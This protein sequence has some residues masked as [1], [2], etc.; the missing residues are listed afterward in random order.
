MSQLHP[1]I[2]EL[3]EFL[4]QHRRRVHEAVASVPAE[5]RERKPAPDRWSVAEVIEHLA[6]IEQ[7]VA[8]LLTKRVTGARAS[9]VGPD[10]RPGTPPCRQPWRGHRP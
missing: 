10:H 1:R 6:M 9:G 4:A 3:I 7:R 2:E 8:A 5:L